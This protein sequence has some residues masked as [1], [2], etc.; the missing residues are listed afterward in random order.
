MPGAAGVSPVLTSLP[1]PGQ[2]GVQGDGRTPSK[3]TD[4]SLSRIVGKAPMTTTATTIR[5]AYRHCQQVTRREARNFYFAFITLPGPK[6]RAIYAAYAFARLC[7]DIADGDGPTAEKVIGLDQVRR[8]LA[9]AYAGYPQGPVFIA[10]ADV[11]RNYGIPQ[12]YFENLAVGVEMDTV[13]S[14]YSTFEELRQ[15]CYGV[16][17]TVGL[18]CAEIFGYTQPIVLEYAVDLG[19]AMQLTNI[20]R[21]IQ[22][23][24]TRGRV[25]L[26]QDEM[27]H[28]GYSEAEL[29]SGTVN[30]QFVELMRFQAQRA[31]GYYA[32]S[33]KLLPLV[34][35]RS[36]AAAAVLHGIYSRLLDRIESQ[37]FNVF[38]GRTRLSGRE[39]LLLTAKL[40]ASSLF[41]S[42]KSA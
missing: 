14:R 12:S 27:A 34:P 41:P 8:S 3:Q 6:R 20:M 30:P 13:K 4:V 40:Y 15:Y 37:G 28:F 29:L 9:D 31:R 23:D 16:A 22:E 33:A 39:K 10:L 32:Q 35:A 42:R 17:G 1:L 21:D 25:Y 24:A 5:E 36:R 11:A 7:D 26:P 18:I 2:E 19:L 38:Q